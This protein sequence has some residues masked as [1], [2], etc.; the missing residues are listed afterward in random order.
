[1]KKVS[2]LRRVACLENRRAVVFNVIAV[3]APRCPRNKRR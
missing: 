3:L 1:M 2:S